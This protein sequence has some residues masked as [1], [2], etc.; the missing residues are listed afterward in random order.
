M[1][2]RKVSS[3]KEFTPGIRGGSREKKVTSAEGEESR[4]G[5]ENKEMIIL[6]EERASL[7]QTFL[8]HDGNK[9]N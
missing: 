2:L 3:G 5:G 7:N 1:L 8:E 4:T 6:I 9:N